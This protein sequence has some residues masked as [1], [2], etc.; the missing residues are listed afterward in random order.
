MKIDDP[1]QLEYLHDAT[2]D[3]I[4]FGY[5]NDSKDMRLTVTCDEECGHRDW[6]GRTLTVTFSNLLRAS[7]TWLGHVMGHD[8]VNSIRE[9]ASADMQQSVGALCGMG[10]D[11]PGRLLRLTFHSGSEIEI[12][13]DEIDVQL[14]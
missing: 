10:I 14:G 9:G 1:E 5:S 4:V 13:C 6:A 2:V 12:A 11:A 3:E 8:T 7:G